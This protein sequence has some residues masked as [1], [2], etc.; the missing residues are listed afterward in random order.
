MSDLP[1]YIPI[2]RI[3][4]GSVLTY[5][6]PHVRPRR[7]DA[8]EA[9]ISNLTRGKFLGE[10]SDKARQKLKKIAVGWLVSVQEGKKGKIKTKLSKK[11]YITFVTL[12]LSAKQVH[13]D[14][15]I[16]RELLNHFL[17]N[18]QREFGVKEYIWRAESQ[19]NGNIHFHLFLDC[20]ISWI[21]LRA[22][23][24]KC[25]ERLGYISRFKQAY[26]HTNP[27]STDIERIRSVK[28]ATIYVT[29]YISKESK[30][31]KLQGRLWGCSDNLKKLLPYEDQFD[32]RYR[33][34]LESLEEN[35]EI[36]VINEVHYRV[37]LGDISQILKQHFHGIASLI[38]N[39]NQ[40]NFRD[41]YG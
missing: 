38:K 8:Q 31:R 27:N 12:T 21:K 18:C 6:V 30:Y 3:Q 25:Q 37:Y 39:H 17:I 29:K 5:A 34:L 16:K 36:R 10:I 4:P 7:T 20:Y 26:N 40:Q 35:K 33:L 11:R 13:T 14:N 1:L 28:G 2:I 19:A 32:S 9:T 24:N 23:W 22:L 15:E 41:L